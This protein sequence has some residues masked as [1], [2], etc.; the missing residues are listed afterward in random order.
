MIFTLTEI[1][2]EQRLHFF[3]LSKQAIQHEPMRHDSW[4]T[5]KTSHTHTPFLCRILVRIILQVP[6]SRF[7]EKAE[8]LVEIELKILHQEQ[9]KLNLVFSTYNYGDCGL[10]RCNKSYFS[11]YLYKHY[12]TQTHMVFW[13]GITLLSGMTNRIIMLSNTVWVRFQL[14]FRSLNK[15]MCGFGKLTLKPASF[16]LFFLFLYFYFFF[17]FNECQCAKF[18]HTTNTK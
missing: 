9:Y 18:S 13:V 2:A 17:L 1:S 15:L 5:N 10:P 4:N 7:D 3:T 11:R 16:S 12:C 8:R 14:M 6:I